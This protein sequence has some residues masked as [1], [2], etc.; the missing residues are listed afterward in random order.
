LAT[1]RS[2]GT[3]EGSPTYAAVAFWVMA[4]CC[5][6]GAI[7]Q[8]QDEMEVDDMYSISREFDVDAYLHM[9]QTFASVTS[10]VAMV[11][12]PV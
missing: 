12:P 2:E 5:E 6:I 10:R 1:S 9:V 7:G 11:G 4:K 3:L 8:T